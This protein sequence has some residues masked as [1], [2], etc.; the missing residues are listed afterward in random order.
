MRR[1]A[2]DI[3]LCHSL[4]DRSRFR[5]ARLRRDPATAARLE[6]W[7]GS[8]DAI[9]SV[10]AS[11]IT[12]S[13]VVE[14]D[15]QR[16]PTA[17][18][19]RRLRTA[20]AEGI[21]AVR[22]PQ[23][24]RQH[25]DE[26]T[27]SAALWR[28]LGLTAVIGVVLVRELWF[29]LPVVHSALSPLGLLTVA[30]SL[31][32]LRRSIAQFR[33]ERRVSLESF[34]GATTLAAVAAGEA[35][36][37]LEV[38]WIHSGAAW[39]TAWISERSRHAISEIMQLSERTTF[40]LVEGVEVAVPAEALNVGDLV[41]VHADERI[42]IDGRV[43]S[44]EALVDEA[45]IT[46]R[47]ELAVRQPGDVVFAGTVVRQGWLHVRV[48]QVG[49]STY[50]ARIFQL[51]EDSLENKAPIEGVADHLARTLVNLGFLATAG[52]FV[53][54]G[55][56]WNAFTVM[57]VMAC[58]CAT[59]LAAS[60]AISAAINAAARR[61]ILIKG[62]RY[63]EEFGKAEIICFDKTGTLTT[64][65]ATVAQIVPLGNASEAEL[66]SWV[67][68]A[69]GHSHH[70]LALALGAAAEARG[71]RPALA[72][73]AE[74]FLGMGVQA[75]LDGHTLLVG[76]RKL[77]E[78]FGINIPVSHNGDVPRPA[79]CTVVYVAKESELVGLFEITQQL[80]PEAPMVVRQL[81]RMGVHEVLL[82]TGDEE[83]VAKALADRLGLAPCFASI[84]P[85]EKA[86]IVSQLGQ[87]GQVV[88]MVGDGVNDAL[89]LA[90]ADI[91][92]AMG[93]GG[94]PVAIEAADIALVRDDLRD[95]VYTHALS[96]DTLDVV[97]Q[98]FWI[99]T[100][101]N[102]LGVV[103]GVAGHLS[104]MTA[105]LIHIVHT[106]GVL[107]NSSRLL[108]YTPDRRRE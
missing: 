70:P 5:I 35:T 38:L 17:E 50:L 91:G 45:P 28:F 101:S 80:R 59:A 66:L 12:G 34:L 32:L 102:V 23:P 63:L 49:R 68:A 72:D 24:V 99:A 108:Q 106:L 73:R 87:N 30:A 96:R 15:W 84:T 52:T 44:G 54:T 67:V 2:T 47:A 61:H 11:A 76:N 74:S 48:E 4:P 58:P 43:E 8:L 60:T 51:V 33:E 75:M 1:H 105:G 14:Y 89:A 42:S 98:N 92:V 13:L 82:V 86:T 21:P 7:V 27:V 29:Q 16:L 22:P 88:V 39:L 81:E 18:L 10:R 20:L 55:S 64:G 94:S 6:A 107:A 90:E 3:Q 97:H 103:L 62:G 57:L 31:P 37:A 46:G 9:R 79:D 65:R 36:T 26:S 25:A 41:A 83:P 56:V 71:L 69:E 95:L 78:R 100:G 53:L 19:E 77:M 93:T 104:P 40:K 85:E